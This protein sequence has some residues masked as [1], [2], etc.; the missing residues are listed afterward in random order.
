[1]SDFARDGYQLV[2]AVLTAE[3][4]GHAA[5]QVHLAEAGKGGTRCLLAEPW[6]TAL[7]QRLRAHQ[8]LASCIPADSV[9]VQ[10]TYF[11][12]SADRN[13]LVPIHQDLSI[14]V[15]ARVDEPSLRGWSE[16]E[17]ALFVQAPVNVLEQLVAVRLHLDECG[18]DDG[19]LKVVAGS[20]KR[21]V[22]TN[23]EAIAARTVGAEQVCL[24]DEGD[25]LVLRPL[26]LH[27]SSKGK[28]DSRRRVLHF[29]FG[30]R[31]L[32]LGLEWKIMQ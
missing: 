2:T 23:D 18:R 27:A 10:C 21:G 19:A 28:G 3:E 25:V 30:P 9:A 4:C 5:A 31:R 11:E 32:P 24:A 26:I 13:W 7:A 15:A 1:V 14:P 8:A 12:K 20:H 17:G 29:V 16:K 22:M 6:C